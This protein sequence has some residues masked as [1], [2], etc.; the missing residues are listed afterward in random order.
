MIYFIDDIKALTLSRFSEKIAAV[1]TVRVN[2]KNMGGYDW[3][4]WGVLTLVCSLMKTIIPPLNTG[5]QTRKSL[6]KVSLHSHK[7][8]VPFTEGMK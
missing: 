1:C 7:E 3:C 4:F 2:Q 5:S 8:K 6:V